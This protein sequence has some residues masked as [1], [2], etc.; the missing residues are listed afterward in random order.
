MVANRRAVKYM[1]STAKNIKQNYIG[2]LKAMNIT[3]I[4][5]P[6]FVVAEIYWYWIEP[7]RDNVHKLSMD[8]CNEIVRD[9]D[10]QVKIWLVLKQV[11]D[12]N[13]PRIVL[14][15]E[16]ILESDN[17]IDLIT[18]SWVQFIWYS[19]PWKSKNL[20]SAKNAE[21]SLFN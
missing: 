1:D 20:R 11:K 7:D 10:Q 6:V 12:N 13:N 3:K 14:Y 19:D 9:D 5:W 4:H 18:R 17:L 15:V 21:P 2:Q 16:E 8:A